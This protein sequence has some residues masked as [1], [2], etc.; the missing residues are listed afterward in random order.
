[1]YRFARMCEPQIQTLVQLR[2][3][4]QK[5]SVTIAIIFRNGSDL[6][7]RRILISVHDKFMPR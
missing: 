1:M 7:Y 3:T 4:Q 2:F 5:W 6:F